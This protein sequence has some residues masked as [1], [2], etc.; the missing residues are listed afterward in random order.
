MEPAACLQRS[1]KS[2]EDGG[3]FPV[4]GTSCRQSCFCR[5]LERAWG[6]PSAEVDMCSL[7]HKAEPESRHWSTTHA[8]VG[9][10]KET[11]LFCTGL[12]KNI[13]SLD[14]PNTE[15]RG[16][17]QKVKVIFKPQSPSAIQFASEFF[18]HGAP[19]QGFP[20]PHLSATGTNS[21]DC[22][23]K[24]QMEHIS[25]E[26]RRHSGLLHVQ[27]QFKWIMEARK[28]NLHSLEALHCKLAEAALIQLL[29]S[30][31]A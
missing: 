24:S 13:R 27:K 4:W 20:H 31:L 19:C 1:G 10:G 2:Q 29:C 17:G 21:S 18:L 8:S 5:P 30:P 6:S 23:A 9:L 28:P 3:Q 7:G 16:S 15:S 11:W 22:A 12:S 14:A 26:H 25:S